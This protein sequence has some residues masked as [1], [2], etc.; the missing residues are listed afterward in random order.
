MN[1]PKAAAPIPEARFVLVSGVRDEAAFLPRVIES[2]IRQTIRPVEWVIVDDASSDATSAILAEAAKENPWIRVLRIERTGERRFG[3]PNVALF[4]QGLAHAETR[5]FGFL[6]NIDG[7][8]VLPP[9]YYEHILARFAQDP[10]LGTLSGRTHYRLGDRFV[11]ERFSG[12]VSFGGAKFYRRACF[13]A[14]GGFEHGPGWDAADCHRCRM[15]GW[16]AGSLD[17]ADLRVE[18]LRRT[19]ASHKSLFHGRMFW[20]RSQWFMGSSLAWVLCGSLYRM[21]ERPWILGGLSVL[22]GYVGAA[23]RR[24]PRIADPA[25]RRH[26]RRW[27]RRRLFGRLLGRPPEIIAP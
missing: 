14:I 3:A 2:V 5:D 8:V 15:L 7:D 12:D 26:L 17:D 19:G 22:L 18:V 4:E 16:K 1:A 9:R 11:S 20:G 21:F 23:V 25:F 10:R 13:E 24:E 6:G 27:Q